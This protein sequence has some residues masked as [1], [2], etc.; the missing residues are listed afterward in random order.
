MKRINARSWDAAIRAVQANLLELPAHFPVSTEQDRLLT[1]VYALCEHLTAEK[2]FPARPTN[3]ELATK[4]A[5]SERTVRNWRR[6]GCPFGE[7]QR[8]VLDWI[9][10]RRYAPAGTRTKFERQLEARRMN[11][12]F[13]EIRGML[14]HARLL[15]L[16]YK[17]AGIELAPDS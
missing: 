12:P 5:I 14:D 1:F 13:V 3:G 2:C 6:E 10:A 9:A 8:R 7:G 17:R 11:R 16:A 15:K 4:Y